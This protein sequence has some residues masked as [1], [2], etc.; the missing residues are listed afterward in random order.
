VGTVEIIKLCVSLSMLIKE[1]RKKTSDLRKQ[2]TAAEDRRVQPPSKLL[3]YRTPTSKQ[4]KIFA[5]FAVPGILYSFNNTLHYHVLRELDMGAYALVSASKV[6]LTAFLM[7]VFLGRKL[8]T[9]QLIALSLL[10]LGS[11]ISMFSFKN[12]FSLRGP[13]IA[14]LLT[15]LSVAISAGASV[16]TEFA[17]KKTNQ[18]IYTQNC[19]LY[20]HG[21]L[22]CFLREFSR[23]HGQ[24]PTFPAMSDTFTWMSIFTL[25]GVGIFTSMVMK[26]ADNLTR[27]FLST[28]SL[29]FSQVLGAVLLGEEFSLQNCVGLTLIL[30]S[31]FLYDPQGQTMLRKMISY[32]PIS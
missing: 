12:G 14:Y 13:V 9:L 6:P 23:D 24:F 27:L 28:S 17:L 5:M 2:S 19:Q 8:H 15:F 11:L 18:G 16:F 25:A 4:A 21:V 29:S 1:N 30:L 10:S 32:Q 3:R 20:F 26:Y 7:R 22:I 31:I